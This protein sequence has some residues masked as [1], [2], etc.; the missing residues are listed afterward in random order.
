MKQKNK[1][2][3]LDKEKEEIYDNLVKLVKTLDKKRNI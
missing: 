2:N 1:K 3:L